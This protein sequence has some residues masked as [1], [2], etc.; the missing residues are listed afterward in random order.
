MVLFQDH[1][2]TLG[3][4]T[5][6]PATGGYTIPS[7]AIWQTGRSNAAISCTRLSAALILALL[8][9]STLAQSQNVSCTCRYQGEDYGLGESICLKSPNGLK[10]ATCEMVLN[11]TSWQISNAPCPVTDLQDEMRQGTD[12]E[13]HAPAT[14][15]KPNGLKTG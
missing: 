2:I 10:M 8:G 5:S 11:N 6:A 9:F 3:R 13:H 4:N 12:G 1:G 7:V 14:P 15:A